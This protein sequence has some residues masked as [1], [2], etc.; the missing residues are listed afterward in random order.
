MN[1]EYKY[2]DWFTAVP[3]QLADNPTGF[4]EWV[5]NITQYKYDIILPDNSKVSAKLFLDHQQ[6]FDNDS[7][8]QN[9]INRYNELQDI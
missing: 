8:T 1:E 7:Y 3:L 2:D 9:L 5:E 6:I 4:N